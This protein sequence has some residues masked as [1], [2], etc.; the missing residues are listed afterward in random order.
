M[1][2]PRY[3]YERYRDPGF[4]ATTWGGRVQWLVFD[5]NS[6]GCMCSLGTEREAAHIVAALNL[7]AGT[8]LASQY[9]EN[10]WR[11][12]VRAERDA[13]PYAERYA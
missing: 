9:E 4:A 7:L 8:D 10:T 5:R 6:I 3:H 1:S 13:V 12:R 11:D 2:D